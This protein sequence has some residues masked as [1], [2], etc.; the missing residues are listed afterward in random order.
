MAFAISILALLSTSYQLYLQRVH[1]EK[2]LKP[3]VQIDLVD[4]SNTI[5]IHIQNNGIGPFIIKQLSYIK[6]GKSY[7][8]LE[9]CLK[10]N[11]RTYQHISPLGSSIKTVLPGSFLPVFSIPVNG[12]K[13]DE[14]FNIR[15]QLADLKVKVD[16]VDI[17][18]NKITVA[19][20]L[21]WFVR[22]QSK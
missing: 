12:E 3:I 22:H 17:Y 18:D 9:N 1:N 10:L 5:A 8:N 19:R 15:Q 16:G 4:T 6:D 2:S 13:A 7:D 11:P 20:D 21:V 14:A